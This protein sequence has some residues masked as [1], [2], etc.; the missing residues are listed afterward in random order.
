MDRVEVLVFL[1]N[2]SNITITIATMPD[3]IRCHIFCVDHGNLHHSQYKTKWV[4]T[5]DFQPECI[6]LQNKKYRF[7]GVVDFV[8]ILQGD[9]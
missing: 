7:K 9:L 8:F 5:S 1:T 3:L 4:T 6:S 2:T